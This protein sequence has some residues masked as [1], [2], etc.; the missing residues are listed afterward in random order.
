MQIECFVDVNLWKG[1]K[2][3]I[4]HLFYDRSKTKTGSCLEHSEN[5]KKS[6]SISKIIVRF[7]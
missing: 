1:G 6:A 2:T 4:V 5:Y 7:E 3:A